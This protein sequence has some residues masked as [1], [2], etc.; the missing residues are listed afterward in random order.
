[1]CKW[2]LFYYF[3]Y[4]FWKF[5]FVWISIRKYHRANWKWWRELE[6]PEDYISI[7]SINSTNSTNS[8]NRTNSFNKVLYRSATL[9]LGMQ[10]LGET[11]FHLRS[12]YAQTIHIKPETVIQCSK[13]VSFYDFFSTPGWVDPQPGRMVL[14]HQSPKVFLLTSHL[15][16]TEQKNPK[17]CIF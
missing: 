1:M 7:N 10:L 12:I 14:D 17:S 3:K 8:I 13:Q 16:C 11:C 15:P 4:I 9:G 5:C 2:K 6:E